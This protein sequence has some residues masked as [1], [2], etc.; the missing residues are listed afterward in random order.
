ML[1]TTNEKLMLQKLSLQLRNLLVN[2]IVLL[3]RIHRA[4]GSEC[5]YSTVLNGLPPAAFMIRGK[6]PRG[7]A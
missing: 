1:L 2:I 4:L 3:C 7:V 6:V 5:D